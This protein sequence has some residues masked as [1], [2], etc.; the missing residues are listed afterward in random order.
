MSQLPLVPQSE[1]QRQVVESALALAQ[2]LER[3]AA[4]APHGQVLDQCEAVALLQGRQFLRDSLAAA[5]QQ[6]I[7]QGEKRGLPPAPVPA[8][9]TAATR[10]PTPGGS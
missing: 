3:A 9:R 10:A 5:L 4:A 8:A 1:F 6:Q 7:C 2:E